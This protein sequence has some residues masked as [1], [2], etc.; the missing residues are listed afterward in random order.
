MTRRTIRPLPLLTL[1]AVLWAAGPLQAAP[2]ASVVA[3][4]PAAQRS[5]AAAA[6]VPLP[7]NSV[8]QLGVKL[9]DQLG[10][11]QGLDAHRGQ[12]VLV[13][14]F[15]SSC[16]FVCPMLIDALRDTEARLSP[17]EQ[18]RVT[19]LMVSFDPDRDTVEVLRRTADERGLDPA[20]WT[21][22][23]SDA[24]SIRKLAGVLGVQYKLLAN[25]DYNH[26]T[27]LIL[28][29]A[30]GRI[31][32]RTTRLGDADPAFVKTVKAVLRGRAG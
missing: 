9:T 1:T 27:A 29:D 20:Q 19:V 28:L 14:M 7:D 18:R 22:A 23:R 32:G 4:A 17:E 15:Y 11:A 10:R 2:P 8:Y 16:Q 6:T 31:A 21:L 12:P 5:P 13:S 25:G 24:A 30:E 26:S 3:P